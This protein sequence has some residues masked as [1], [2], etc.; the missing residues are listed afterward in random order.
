MR[1]RNSCGDCRCGTGRS[2]AH[3]VDC[4]GSSR[5][6][7]R[8][9]HH[10]NSGPRRMAGSDRGYRRLPTRRTD[11]EQHLSRGTELPDHRGVDRGAHGCRAPSP[12][13]GRYGDQRPRG[14]GGARSVGRRWNRAVDGRAHH[15]VHD[16]RGLDLAGG[17][18]AVQHLL[19]AQCPAVDVQAACASWIFGLDMAIRLVATGLRNVL[20]IGADVKSRF[21]SSDDHRLGPVLADGAGAVVLDRHE[22]TGGFLQVE[23]YTD[24]SKVGNLFTPAGGS[25]MPAS[26]ETVAQQLHATQLAIAGSEIKEH[27]SFVMAELSRQVC[28]QEGIE[29]SDVDWLVPHQANAAILRHLSRE[30]EIDPARIANTIARAGNI[31]AGTLPFSL[32]DL[33]RRGE[34]E[35]GQLILLVTAGA[36]YAGG[37]AS[38][39]FRRDGSGRSRRR[40]QSWHRC[41]RGATF[42]RRRPPRSRR[43]AGRRGVGSRRRRHPRRRDGRRRRVDG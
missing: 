42:G 23:L 13:R 43:G 17:C 29:P 4:A 6:V 28:R 15:P 11:R 8:H 37:V 14:P 39:R 7:E 10:E 30:L 16:H 33:I 20:V 41:H 27:V 26:A 38:T 35:P 1:G 32:D 12:R 31:V 5:E 36:G 25:A 22:G 19:G 24:G 9:R 3:Q 2:R 40:S 21:V 34:I 18:I